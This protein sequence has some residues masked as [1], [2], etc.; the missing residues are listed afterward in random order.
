VIE[1]LCESRF[2]EENTNGDIS[3]AILYSVEDPC[4]FFL[5]SPTF[6][7]IACGSEKQVLR[8]VAIKAHIV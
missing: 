4:L 2:A 6:S 8:G 1:L 5:S 3:L 7:G